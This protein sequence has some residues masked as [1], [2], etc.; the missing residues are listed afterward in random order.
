MPVP[1]ADQLVVLGVVLSTALV[2]LFVV[3][4]AAD[5]DGRLAIAG[6]EPVL[7]FLARV[8]LLSIA[9]AASVT[10]SLTVA[11]LLFTPM[12]VLVLAAAAWFTAITYGIVGV[13]VGSQL[14]KLPGV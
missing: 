14:D 12:N 2:G 10:V 8:V 1:L 9:G 4:S 7:L 3:Q 5:A 11:V 13:I 6:F